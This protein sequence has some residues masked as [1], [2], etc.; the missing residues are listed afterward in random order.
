[1]G[2]IGQRAR[3]GAVVALTAGLSAAA[4]AAT[5]V[6]GGSELKA[7][8]GAEGFGTD[9]AGGRGGRV[10]EVTNLDDSGAGSFRA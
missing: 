9:T 2:R 1:M 3:L 5:L 6:G 8:T 7:F 10:I 4:A